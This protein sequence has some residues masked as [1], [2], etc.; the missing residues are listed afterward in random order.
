M[1]VIKDP[2]PI[3]GAPQ[4]WIALLG[5][6]D[7]PVDGVEDYCTFVGRALA[8]REI[9]LQISRVSW[10]EQGW[11]AALRQLHLDC[12]KWAGHWAILQYTA[13]SWSRRGF[14]FLA[15]VVL[16]ILRKGGARVAVVF[17]EPH[18]QSRTSA[19]WIDQVRGACQDW[20]IRRLY[21]S[22]AKSVFTVPL[23][24]IDWL[25]KD[26][27]E[28][29][30]IPIGA[31][32]APWSPA[33]GNQRADLAA[34]S[35]IVFCLD[36]MPALLQQ[37]HDISAAIRVAAKSGARLRVVFVGR[38]T[39]E[40]AAEIS[41]SL[42]NLPVEISILGLL[43]AEA[44]TDTFASADAMLCVRGMVN[45]CRSSVIAG[46]ACG[47]PIVA[48]G[49]D[50]EGTPLA[51]AGLMLVPFRDTEALGAALGRLL[52]DGDLS[53]QLRDKSHRAHSKTFSWD[54]IAASYV[55]FLKD[56]DN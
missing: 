14:P 19:R 24:T 43:S 40:A 8:E 23:N 13:L 27:A 26:H 48:Y 12:K 38:G 44:L 31:S 29:A 1:A 11:I 35:V 50:V 15:L 5:H 2:V 28:A 51:D 33:S 45:Q 36:G 53:L 46:I 41:S 6:R 47:L 42:E 3:A 49:G 37:L 22:A 21:Q 32:L 54:S 34:R 39:K 7:T 16:A 10:A 20:V 9:D 55:D 56:D 18:R 4:R 52:T 30:F 17:H 25:P